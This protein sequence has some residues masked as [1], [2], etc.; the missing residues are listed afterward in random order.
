MRR[1]E[2]TVN[3]KGRVL[4]IGLAS[5]LLSFSLVPSA[6]GPAQALT[7]AP[8]VLPAAV[9]AVAGTLTISPV[10]NASGGSV[11]ATFPKAYT[12]KNRPV[13]LWK[14]TDPTLGTWA[15]VT[16]AAKVK[17]SS[18]GVAIFTV[19]PDLSTTYKA[20]APEYRYKV[21]KKWKTGVAVET[22]P[23]AAAVKQEFSDNFSGTD[24][25][26]A[27]WSRTRDGDYGV[28]NR[29]CSAPRNANATVSQSLASLTMSKPNLSASRKAQIVA[30]AKAAQKAAKVKAVGC[31]H[32]IFD[33]ARVSTEGNFSMQSGIIAAKV[34]FPKA[35]GMHGGIWVRTAPEGGSELDMVE[36]FGLRKGIQNVVHI[37]VR[38]TKGANVYET[39]ES[40]KW[41]AKS[42]VNKSSWWDKYHVFSMEW[43]T[44][45]VTFRLDGKITKVEKPKIGIPA[46]DYYIVMSMLSSDW[47][48]GRL[49]K[50]VNHGKKAKLPE[51][52]KVDWIKAWKPV[53]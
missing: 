9:N 36:A 50:P 51:S 41:V 52:M 32:G 42:T 35:Q 4:T 11:T 3:R 30:D 17:L 8:A 47:E 31:P 20:I 13:Y 7:P 34:K 26:S 22:A 40:K 44:T 33:N 24:Y 21:K 16:E 2:K 38:D 45:T 46:E 27:W 48:T 49:T 12:I 37:G 29:W 5:A 15:Q 6:G 18:T 39:K 19:T 14:L 28:A 25:D 1:L 10:A 23:K 43:N 53:A